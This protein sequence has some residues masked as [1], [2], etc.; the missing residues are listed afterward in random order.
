[1]TSVVVFGAG[2]R[3]GRA[4]LAAA[5]ARGVPATAVVRDNT[6]YPDILGART[7]DATDAA[8]VADVARGHDV[9]IVAVYS[10]EVGTGDYAKHT[11]AL[12]AGLEA[13]AVPKLLL[14]GL[15]TTLR[16]EP[17]GDRIFEA[18]EFNP[19]WR[20]FS[21]GRAGELAVLEGY[22]GTVDWVVLTPP[23]A[24]VEGDDPGYRIQDLGSPL[25]YAGLAAA[26]LDEVA[27]DRHHRVQI[28]VS[29]N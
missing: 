10:A 26:L 13:A 15:A 28:G 11:A 23:M 1:M 3:A 6:K 20:P 29:G 2:G 19:E 22:T 21:E 12:L 25:T 4:V 5:R 18:A 14:V 27:A 17:G 16:A 24:L 8:L 9:A 7:G